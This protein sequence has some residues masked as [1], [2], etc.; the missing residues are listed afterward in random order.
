V[1]RREAVAHTMTSAW[2]GSAG[3]IRRAPVSKPQLR[4][5]VPATLLVVVIVACVAAPL[6]APYSPTEIAPSLQFQA[7]SLQHV[8]GTDGLGRDLFSRILYAGRI[9]IVI[10]GSATC[11]A[12][13]AGV[14]WGTVA[15]VRGGIAEEVLMRVADVFMAV[16]LLL[17]ALMLVVVFGAN[18][19]GLIA[20]MA[21]L[22]A[23]WIARI[24][25]AVAAAELRADY[26]TAATAFG[27]SR[28]R[29][30]T[31]ELLPNLL[32]T[33]RTQATLVFAYSILLESTLSFIGL[34]VQPPDASWGTLLSDGYTNIYQ[35]YYGIVF[36]GVMII[37]VAIALNTIA[38]SYDF[39]KAL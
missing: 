13:L 6:L 2:H 19:R 34:G 29:L 24:I 1:T 35:S 5:V 32:P 17:F 28:S 15:A 10:S 14:A 11:L 20:I 8:F 18:V 27:T 36:P 4:T 21:L 33:I 38:D 26:C 7:P 25:R 39:D 12:L 22:Q 31:H 16:P 9:T 23:P 3:A 37:I 30:L